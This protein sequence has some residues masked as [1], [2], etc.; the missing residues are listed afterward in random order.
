MITMSLAEDCPYETGCLN[1]DESVIPSSLFQSYQGCI[2]R[3]ATSDGK[4]AA[5]LFIKSR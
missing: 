4:H 3:P 2:F 5:S 1:P